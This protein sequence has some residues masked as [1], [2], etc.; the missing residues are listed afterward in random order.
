MNVCGCADRPATPHG[1]GAS[2]ASRSPGTR[3]RGRGT[4]AG[5]P[6][7]ATGRSQVQLVLGSPPVLVTARGV[8]RCGGEL[9]R[10][11]DGHAVRRDEQMCGGWTLAGERVRRRRVHCWPVPCATD[12]PVR[13]RPRVTNAGN[14]PEYSVGPENTACHPGRCHLAHDERTSA[15]HAPGCRRGRR[16]RARAFEALL[17]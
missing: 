11:R 12:G 4:E 9:R 7:V 8:F 13:S 14:A 15:R 1:L 16:L 5:K 17:G 2:S 3:E 6:W 10:L